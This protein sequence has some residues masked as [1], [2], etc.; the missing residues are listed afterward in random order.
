MVEAQMEYS[1][2]LRNP[3]SEVE[4]RC[5]TEGHTFR[6]LQHVFFMFY[7]VVEDYYFLCATSTP[8]ERTHSGSAGG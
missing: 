6:K 1:A 3:E 7:L 4:P 5:R 8:A 2:L